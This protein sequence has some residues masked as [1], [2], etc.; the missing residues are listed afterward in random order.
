M[1]DVP[2]FIV[3][4]LCI[5]VPRQAD[6]QRF[7]P[8]G[9]IFKGELDTLFNSDVLPDQSFHKRKGIF[10]E[11]ELVECAMVTARMHH[12]K[13]DAQCPGKVKQADGDVGK[14]ILNGVLDVFCKVLVKC[15]ASLRNI[16]SGM[17]G[18][19]VN[20]AWLT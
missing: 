4:H 15:H 6:E 20:I 14:F 16:S 8:I 2:V 7:C 12:V 18:Y 13:I 11:G 19:S 9:D 10:G 1:P 5:N 17:V 3:L